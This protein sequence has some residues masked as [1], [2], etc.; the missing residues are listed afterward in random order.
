MAMASFKT[1]KYIEIKVNSFAPRF[2]LFPLLVPLLILIR[3]V[4]WR[5]G[6]G[7]ANLYEQIQ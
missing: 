6:E 4:G 5:G 7:G 2:V 3:T 1:G